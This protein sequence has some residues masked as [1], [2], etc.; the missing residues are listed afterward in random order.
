MRALRDT[1]VGVKIRK[2]FELLKES[3]QEARELFWEFIAAV[4]IGI[5]IVLIFL[6]IKYF[7]VFP[8]IL[9]GAVIFYAYRRKKIQLLQ[10]VQYQARISFLSFYI[11]LLFAGIF[12]GNSIEKENTYLLMLFPVEFFFIFW[13]ASFFKIK[14]LKEK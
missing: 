6:F 8:P 10:T 2:N 3:F 9:A 13:T 1:A 5:I 12:A 14:L 4:T 7:I 11:I